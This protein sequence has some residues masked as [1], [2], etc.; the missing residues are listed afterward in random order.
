LWWSVVYAGIAGI[1][2]GGF[3]ATV[4]VDRLIALPTQATYYH[5]GFFYY[6][7]PLYLLVPPLKALVERAPKPIVL[8]L[9]GVWITLTS[10]YLAGYQGPWSVD[11]AMFGG[12]LLLGFVLWQFGSPSLAVMATLGV[13]ALVIGDVAVI[14]ESLEEDRYAI[15]RWFSYKTINTVLVAALVFVL[16]ILAAPRVSPR[17]GHAIGFVG[18][19]SLGI[20]FLHPLFLWPVRAF[21]LY[22]GY[23]LVVI[24]CWALVAGSLA[25][26]TSVILGRFRVTSWMVP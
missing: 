1:S 9:L 22:V 2:T 25:L 15:G 14:F 4:V 23:P 13:A 10:F 6:F 20:Y 11:L 7:I 8:A 24:A 17:I 26:A 18:R 21:D 3:D 16:G 5:L 12:Y 19:N